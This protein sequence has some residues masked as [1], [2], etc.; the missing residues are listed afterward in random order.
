[1]KAV[2]YRAW[3]SIA[4]A[5]VVSARCDQE[6]VAGLPEHASVLDV[7]CHDCAASLEMARL[8]PDLTVLG[9][10][11]NAAAI[12]AA[13]T[14]AANHKNATFEV[15]DILLD[16]PRQAFDA[17]LTIRVLTCFPDRDDGAR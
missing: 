14:R 16:P 8:R 15:R 1:M 10:D 11:I 4:Y 17:V 6:F 13:R 3:R 7:G 2:G 5:P 12:D 9:I